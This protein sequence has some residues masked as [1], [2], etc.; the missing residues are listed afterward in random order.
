MSFIGVF[1]YISV[2]SVFWSLSLVLLCY[3]RLFIYPV[4]I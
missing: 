4:A 3:I 1:L 2:V